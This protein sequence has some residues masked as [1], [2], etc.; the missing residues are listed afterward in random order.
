MGTRILVLSDTHIPGRGR[1]LPPAV[2]EAAA[3]ADLIVHA[4]DLVS[5]DVY[6]ELALLAPVVAVCGNVDDPEVYRRLPPRAVVEREGVRI[7]VTHGHLGKGATT[8]DRALAAFA[9]DV[10]PPAVVIFGH[11]HQPLIERR[12]DVL[13]FNPGSPTDPRRAPAPTYGWLELEAGVAR[14]RLVEL[15]RGPRGR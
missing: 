10:P 13:L 5:L 3:Q 8:P 2:L 1:S 4:G 11:S 12:G 15:P 6:D 7:G 14:A 9:T